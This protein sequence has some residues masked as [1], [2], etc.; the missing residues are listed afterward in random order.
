M[1]LYLIVKDKGNIRKT[2]YDDLASSV[3]FWERVKQEGKKDKIKVNYRTEKV[4]AQGINGYTRVY[5][6]C[7]RYPNNETWE[8]FL[9]SS[10]KNKYIFKV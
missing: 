6:I 5:Y 10:Q 2:I 9:R 7:V 8:Y 1:A 4:K 3:L